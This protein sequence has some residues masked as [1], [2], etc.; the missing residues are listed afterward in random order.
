MFAAVAAVY[1]WTRNPKR[2]AFLLPLGAAML[3]AV[4]VKGI[5]NCM[6]G[7]IV[8]RGTHYSANG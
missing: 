6:T 8:W 1:A 2:Y 4:F 7:R 5:M 3:V